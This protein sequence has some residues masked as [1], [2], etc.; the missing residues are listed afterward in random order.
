MRQEKSM[1]EAAYEEL[2]VSA[3]CPF[4][5]LF[6]KVAASL[7]MSDE[8]RDD[9]ISD[10]LTDLTMDGRFVTFDG[11][12]WDLRERHQSDKVTFRASDFAEEGE[13]ALEEEES[14]EL[15]EGD[16]REELSEDEEGF[17]KKD[18]ISAQELGV[19]I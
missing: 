16:G 11:L 14:S 4:A 18:A 3:A 8:E 15:E 12:N 6:A 13:E 17:E 19:N 9:R 2:K 1:V 5:E 10:F 7:E